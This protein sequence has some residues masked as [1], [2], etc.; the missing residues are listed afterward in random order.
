MTG[1]LRIALALTTPPTPPPPHRRRRRRRRH[2]HRRPTP[3]PYLSDG[4][5]PRC[6]HPSPRPRSAPPPPARLPT[7][8]PRRRHFDDQVIT[9]GDGVTE[10]EDGDGDGAEGRR[11]S[12]KLSDSRHDA[13]HGRNIYQAI[14]STTNYTCTLSRYLVY[15]GL[16]RLLR[17]QR[18]GGDLIAG[19]RALGWQPYSRRGGTFIALWRALGW[20]PD[21]LLTMNLGWHPDS[22]FT[23]MQTSVQ[24]EER[25]KGSA[26]RFDGPRGGPGHPC[27]QGCA[28]RT[29]GSWRS[30]RYAGR[31]AQ[32][33]G[34]GRSGRPISGCHLVTCGGG[35]GDIGNEGEMISSHV[36][37]SKHHLR[38][39]PGTSSRPRP[40]YIASLATTGRW[41]RGGVGGQITRRQLFACRRYPG[42]PVRPVGRQRHPRPERGGRRLAGIGLGG[43]G[44]RD[45]ATGD[46]SH[47]AG[48]DP[49]IFLLT[50]D[51]VSHRDLGVHDLLDYLT[52]HMANDW[53]GGLRTATPSDYSIV[54]LERRPSTWRK[55]LSEAGNAGLMAPVACRHGTYNEVAMDCAY[56]LGGLGGQASAGREPNG[57]TRDDAGDADGDLRRQTVGGGRGCAH[58]GWQYTN[59]ALDDWHEGWT[60]SSTSSDGALPGS[61][62]ASSWAAAVGQAED[63]ER[64]VCLCTEAAAG[65]DAA[66]GIVATLGISLTP[67]GPIGSFEPGYRALLYHLAGHAPS[68]GLGGSTSSETSCRGRLGPRPPLPLFRHPLP[69]DRKRVL[70]RPSTIGETSSDAVNNVA[71][72]S[73]LRNGTLRYVNATDWTTTGDLTDECGD[74]IYIGSVMAAGWTVAACAMAIISSMCSVPLSLGGQPPRGN[75]QRRGHRRTKAAL[76]AARTARGEKT[77]KSTRPGHGL[78]R[79]VAW[80]ARWVGGRRRPAPRPRRLRCS[81]ARWANHLYA[82][83]STATNLDEPT[84]SRGGGPRRYPRLRRGATSP[85]A[86]NYWMLTLGLIILC[87]QVGMPDGDVARCRGHDSAAPDA[88]LGIGGSA[89]AICLKGDAGPKAGGAFEDSMDALE[90]AFGRSR[91]DDLG[92]DDAA[93]GFLGGIGDELKEP[94][95]WRCRDLGTRRRPGPHVC[96]GRDRR[97]VPD[98]WMQLHR[99]RELPS[100]A[101]LR[102]PDA[103]SVSGDLTRRDDRNGGLWKG[104][105]PGMVC[106]Q[107]HRTPEPPSR[108]GLGA[109]EPLEVRPRGQ[110]GSR[111]VMPGHETSMDAADDDVT[112]TDCGFDFDDTID[113]EPSVEVHRHCDADEGEGGCARHGDAHAFLK[114]GVDER[115]VVT[116]YGSTSARADYEGPGSKRQAWTGGGSCCGTH[117]A[118]YGD[119]LGHSYDAGELAAFPCAP[120]EERCSGLAGVVMADCAALRCGAPELSLGT[121]VGK[122]APMD[123]TTV[124]CSAVKAGPHMATRCIMA[125]GCRPHCEGCVRRVQP[126]CHGDA[127]EP[128]VRLV[129]DADVRYCDL[130]DYAYDTWTNDGTRDE[131]DRRHGAD[132]G[133]RG[134]DQSRRDVLPAGTGRGAGRRK[135]QTSPAFDPD[136]RRNTAPAELLVTLG[137]PYDAN[138]P[139]CIPVGLASTSHGHRGAPRTT[140]LPN[141]GERCGAEHGDGCKAPWLTATSTSAMSPLGLLRRPSLA[142]GQARGGRGG[143]DWLGGIATALFSR[144]KH[145]EAANPPWWSDSCRVGEAANPGPAP[146][147]PRPRRGGK[148]EAPGSRR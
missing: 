21:S 64:C 70:R 138:E 35:M 10:G 84:R 109:A 31:S 117:V 20:H 1:M 83:V 140:D 80:E 116:C 42:P 58:D 75:V 32:Q 86:R 6:P 38:H 98:A 127:P 78:L 113:D 124:D 33:P 65:L 121:R 73:P 111:G 105:P 50:G 57:E 52:W 94:D 43:I 128:E 136:E 96:E 37:A 14:L 72:S 8:T 56:G 119:H 36:T 55:Q 102:G 48:S 147:P 11:V 82:A 68:S 51:L 92:D 144:R 28:L 67:N 27:G 125:L 76:A 118:L 101:R 139:E 63:F 143:G 104:C 106:R 47:A 129:D 29:S 3:S 81:S 39:R 95:A 22:L 130:C 103:V 107:M 71:T 49:G 59:A 30:R 79:S 77:D 12:M 93:E 122:S 74:V 19:G 90:V 133:G 66:A 9:S 41:G 100:R 134:T 146:T 112:C 126:R 25:R 40:R 88:W 69:P 91:G 15:R 2:P 13:D 131:D 89:P 99:P 87:G 85:Y 34:G 54:T 123:V 26:E 62:D 135:R 60:S 137:D 115:Q 142:S 141:D 44:L 23:Q 45:C 7:L 145:G 148:E 132:D 4:D 108:A 17:N 97:E 18:K 46:S 114:T 61:M 110:P 5:A 24:M 16:W 120:F 53:M